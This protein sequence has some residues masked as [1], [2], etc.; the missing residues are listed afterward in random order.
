MGCNG[1]RQVI[2]K[3]EQLLIQPNTEVLPR[4]PWALLSTLVVFLVFSYLDRTILALVVDPVRRSL[5]FDDQQIGLLIGFALAFAYAIAGIPMGWLVDRFDR[6]VVLFGGVMFWGIATAS[7]G[8]VSTFEEFF[9]VRMLIG[10]GEAVLTPASHSLIPDVFPAKRLGIAF[11]I[12]SMGSYIGAG[13]A[14]I[15]G[16]YAVHLLLRRA[17]V[18]LPFLGETDAW[19]G[20]FVLVGLLGAAL[21]P[22]IFLFREPP[23]RHSH[24]SVPDGTAG[25]E[26]L[27]A[28]VFSNWKIWIMFTLTFGGMTACNAA[29][30]FWQPTYMSRFFHWNA[31]QFGLGLGLTY[32]VAGTIGL[33]F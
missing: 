14:L 16:G 27:A 7:C 22:L 29:L 13:F 2:G 23:R 19:R 21:S 10:I 15:G 1:D 30:T 5:G 32:A 18:M 12:F 28:F 8:Y 20:V 3:A 6:R 25:R 4:R 11:S 26:R 24:G 17:G 31:A 33:T 9:V